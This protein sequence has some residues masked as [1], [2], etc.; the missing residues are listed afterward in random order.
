MANVSLASEI[1]AFMHTHTHLLTH[2]VITESERTGGERSAV[3]ALCCGREG[4]SPLAA[5]LAAERAS[6]VSIYY[7]VV[8]A[9]FGRGGTVDGRTA[10]SRVRMYTQC[11]ERA[12][13]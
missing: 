11:S 1:R 10:E 9:L 13:L 2:N 7:V 5:L 12:M 8:G 6:L 4:A 3:A